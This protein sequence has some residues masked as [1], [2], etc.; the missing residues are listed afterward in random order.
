MKIINSFNQELIQIS[1]YLLCLSILLNFFKDLKQNF[2][3]FLLKTYLICSISFSSQLPEYLVESIYRPLKH[4]KASV[5]FYN[6]SLSGIQFPE[7]EMKINHF[8]LVLNFLSRFIIPF[9]I[10]IHTNEITLR[11]NLYFS[12]FYLLP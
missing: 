8:K 1:F 10:S 2:T 5:R 3:I 7:F 11:F 12:S 9:P 4:E 6:S